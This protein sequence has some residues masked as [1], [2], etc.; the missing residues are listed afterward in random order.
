MSGNTR[1]ALRAGASDAPRLKRSFARRSPGRSYGF[2][3]RLRAAFPVRYNSIVCS[4]NVSA[5]AAISSAIDELAAD[6]RAGLP[7][8]DLATRVAG[9][10]TMLASLDPELARRRSGYEEGGGPGASPTLS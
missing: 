3:E 1:R 6:S 5:L 4:I 2:P 7:A 10:W 9:I 8:A